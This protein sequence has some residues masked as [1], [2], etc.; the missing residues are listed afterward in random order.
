MLFGICSARSSSAEGVLVAVGTCQHLA[1]V[2][3]EEFSEWLN[4]SFGLRKCTGA[5]VAAC[6][7]V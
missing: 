6:M 4:K 2:L 1:A 5:F 7:L 3:E